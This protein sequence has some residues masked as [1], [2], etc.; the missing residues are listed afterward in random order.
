MELL[1]QIL[2]LEA[3]VKVS[4]CAYHP[5]DVLKSHREVSTEPSL[6]QAKPHQLSQPCFMGEEFQPSRNFHGV[7]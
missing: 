1:F 3:L 7:I 5:P 4:L 6:L 2:S